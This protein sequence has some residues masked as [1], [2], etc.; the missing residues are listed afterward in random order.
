V[1]SIYSLAGDKSV[2][3]H[4]EKSAG[5]CFPDFPYL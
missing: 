3:V 4:G 1:Y 5:F 2:G